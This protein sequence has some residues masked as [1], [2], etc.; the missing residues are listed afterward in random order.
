MIFTTSKNPTI[1][2]R[3]CEGSSLYIA[4]PGDDFETVLPKIKATIP[5][6]SVLVINYVDKFTIHVKI[7]L[8][9]T[10]DSFIF[11]TFSEVTDYDFDEVLAV[12]FKR[13][14]DLLCTVFSPKLLANFLSPC[15]LDS[16][17]SEL[18]NFIRSAPLITVFPTVTLELKEHCL[19][20]GG[21][22]YYLKQNGFQ[23]SLS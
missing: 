23:I 10:A 4:Q 13:G 7:P 22:K 1:L 11:V 6:L 16:Y 17:K 8:L 15:N 2:E 21:S 5:P 3:Q 20:L 19:V 12:F 9:F 14:E 18:C